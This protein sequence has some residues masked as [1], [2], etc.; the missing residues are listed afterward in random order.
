MRMG[1]NSELTAPIG[2]VIDGGVPE[3]WGLSPAYRVQVGHRVA[4]EHVFSEGAHGT[5]L[6]DSLCGCHWQLACQCVCPIRHQRETAR[7]GKPPVAPRIEGRL[8]CHGSHGTRIAHL[9]FG[10]GPEFG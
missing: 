7:A 1:I 10:V 6:R 9:R 3:R 4:H 8:N 2:T 5:R